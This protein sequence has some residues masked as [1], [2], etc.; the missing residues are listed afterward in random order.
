MTRLRSGLSPAVFVEVDSWLVGFIDHGTTSATACT[1]HARKIH[2]LAAGSIHW[3]NHHRRC[4]GLPAGPSGE[5]C[6]G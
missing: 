3:S 6:V 1:G 2:A 4:L 5:F